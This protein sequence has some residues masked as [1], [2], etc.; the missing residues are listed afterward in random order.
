MFLRRQFVPDHQPNSIVYG[1]KSCKAQKGVVHPRTK[2]MKRRKGKKRKMDG[3]DEEGE[4]KKE[5]KK[6]KKRKSTMGPV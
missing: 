3:E 5:S 1:S 6:E 2:R 4:G